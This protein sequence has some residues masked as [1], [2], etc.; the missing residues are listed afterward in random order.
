MENNTVTA[1]SLIASREA[2]TKQIRE[3]IPTA[4]L[5]AIKALGNYTTSGYLDYAEQ[6]RKNLETLNSLKNEF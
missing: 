4:I 6:A 2:T 1:A 3:E 5:E